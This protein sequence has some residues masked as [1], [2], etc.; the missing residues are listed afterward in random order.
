[1]GFNSHHKKVKNKFINTIVDL[2]SII[3]CCEEIVNNISQENLDSLTSAIESFEDNYAAM[4]VEINK[5]IIESVDDTK[6]DV[7]ET[8]VGFEL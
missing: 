5:L 4:K 1:M 3:V 8:D 6:I 2:S 7:K